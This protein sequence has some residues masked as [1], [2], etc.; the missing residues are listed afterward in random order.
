MIIFRNPDE[1]R[2]DNLQEFRPRWLDGRNRATCEEVAL[3][4]ERMLRSCEEDEEYASEPAPSRKG[5]LW[6]S[7][8]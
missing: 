2:R 7:Y 1:D 5:C 3:R 8:A 4:L 6:R